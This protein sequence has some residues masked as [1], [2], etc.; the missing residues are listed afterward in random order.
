MLA[1][2][3]WLQEDI[4]MSANKEPLDEA[5]GIGN[6]LVVHTPVFH[7]GEIVSAHILL[8][9]QLIDRITDKALSGIDGYVGNDT[10]AGA[11][12]AWLGRFA[13][14]ELYD[15]GLEV[16]GWTANF[17]M[18]IVGADVIDPDRTLPFLAQLGMGS[19]ALSTIEVNPDIIEVETEFTPRAVAF[20]LEQAIIE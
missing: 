1:F 5:A 19:F 17:N 9:A 8:T 20:M 14:D 16:G 10:K 15:H 11:A 18:N 6:R 2:I 12:E 7:Q 3:V 13:T 4:F